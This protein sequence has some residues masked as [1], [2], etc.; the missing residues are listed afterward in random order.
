MRHSVAGEG[1]GGRDGITKFSELTEWTEGLRV[2]HGGVT[3]MMWR[4]VTV[5]LD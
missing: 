2:L 1:G 3:Q 4:R 5:A